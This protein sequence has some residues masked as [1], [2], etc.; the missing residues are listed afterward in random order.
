MAKKIVESGLGHLSISLDSSRPE[1]H[2]SFRGV[3]GVTQRAVRAVELVKEYRGHKKLPLLSLTSII[4]KD[5]LDDLNDLVSLVKELS[6]D[7]NNFQVLMSKYSFGSRPYD[8][9]WHKKNPLW[10]NNTQKTS[11]IIK[12]LISLKKSGFSIN[13]PVS[14]LER[15]RLYFADPDC[16]NHEAC[17]VGLS[18]FAIDIKGDV[19]LCFTMPPIGNIKNHSPEEI[20]KGKEAEKRRIEIKNCKKNCRLLLCNRKLSPGQIF[21]EAFFRWSKKIV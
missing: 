18:N 4:M 3:K 17:L 6:L 5:N 11:R 21:K 2:D 14:E 7:G 13:N 8:S 19:R 10:P 12:Q 20:W 15:F 9:L 16:F 1:V